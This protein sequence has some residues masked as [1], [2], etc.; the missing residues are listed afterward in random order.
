M[1]GACTARTTWRVLATRRDLPG[2][3]VH[4]CRQI[5]FAIRRFALASLTTLNNVR[6]KSSNFALDRDLGPRFL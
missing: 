1:R 4:K 3:V 6:A 5:D 2:A